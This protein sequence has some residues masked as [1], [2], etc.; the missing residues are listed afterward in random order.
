MHNI[1]LPLV[2][3]ILFF[4]LQC[5]S[6]DP[7]AGAAASLPYRLDQP[8]ASFDLPKELTEI[9]GLCLDASRQSLVCVSDETGVLFQLSPQTG[10]IQGRIPFWED[11]DFEGVEIVGGNAWAVKSSGSVFYV[12]GYASQHPEI[13]K[14]KTTLTKENDVEGLG[15]D[16]ANNR[17]L[18][19][20]KGKAAANEASA[21]KKAIFGFDLQTQTMSEAPIFEITLDGVKA[22]LTQQAGLSEEERQ[23]ILKDFVDTDGSMKFGPS[24]IAVHP[25]TS[26]IY[27]TSARGNSLVVLSKNGAIQHIEKLKKR[28]HA[29]P[30]GI[31][32]APDGTLFISSE[33]V[34]AMPGRILQFSYKP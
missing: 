17:L 14:I 15:F 31:C 29:Q 11:G 28:T 5:Q 32:F 10:E 18:V 7:A 16:A 6:T 3:P 22:F 27:V 9:S 34:D 12:E 21:A 4:A 24:G 1:L 30:E 2:S 19:G 33:G 13:A 26:E 20:C 8:D 23:K 25:L